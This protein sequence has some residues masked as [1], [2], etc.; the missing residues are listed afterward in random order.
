MSKRL[1]SLQDDDTRNV[2]KWEKGINATWDI[3]Q[4]DAAGNL[5]PI[6]PSERERSQFSKKSRIN[7]SIRRGLI[8]F[9]IIAIDL[10]HAAGE[11]DYRPSRL[12]VC[13]NALSQFILNYY[14]QNPIS[15]LS[16]ISTQDRISEK[17]TDLSGNSRSHINKLQS[18]Y[19]VKGLASLQNTLFLAF[20]ILKH[21]PS[22]GSREI[23]IVYSSLSTC[24]PGN[25]F[26]TI[27]QLKQLHIRVN[28]ICLSAEIHFCKQITEMTKG[29]Y[30]VAMDS[31]H[32]TELLNVL[33]TP[34]ADLRDSK[35]SQL[36]N[37]IKMKSDFI[38]MGFPKRSIELYSSFCYDDK[39]VTMTSMSFICPRC[40]TK[41]M[42]I[43]TICAVCHLQLNSSS[44]IARSFHHLF[45]VSSFLECT[46]VKDIERI[47]ENTI[48]Y[49]EVYEKVEDVH[50]KKRLKIEETVEN[51]IEIPDTPPPPPPPSDSQEMDSSPPPP[52]PLS[53]PLPSMTNG[54]S[55]RILLNKEKARCKGCYQLLTKENKVIF[56]CPNCYFFFCIDCDIFIHESLHN[57]PSCL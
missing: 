30:A 41:T 36:Q 10:S 18:L 22:Y 49:A 35:E 13:K 56:Q 26:E 6:L 57:C 54:E 8:R 55:E 31:S 19:E 11:K 4:E 12:E 44:H 48:F 40:L 24:D 15:Q 29:F 25:I 45:P 21:I 34:P 50:H 46:V 27:S 52:P 39:Q 5:I 9:F 38:Y 2:Y 32:L 3:V 42:D 7:K 1:A 43:P 51:V 14:D 23:L 47:T 37:G 20:N 28:I 17:L 16:L 33:I 53:P